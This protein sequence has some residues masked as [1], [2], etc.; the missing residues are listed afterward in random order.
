MLVW[1]IPST[2]GWFSL[3]TDDNLDILDG[4]IKSFRL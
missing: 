3:L 2:H 4:G 1:M